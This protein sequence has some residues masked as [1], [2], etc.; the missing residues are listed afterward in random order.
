M[1]PK[2]A[3]VLM[4]VGVVAH[5]M[6]CGHFP[7]FSGNERF[8]LTFNMSRIGHILELPVTDWSV[9]FFI[10]SLEVIR[11]VRYI[12]AVESE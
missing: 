4:T 11:D 7:F 9:F 12:V 1:I 6:S 10:T 3:T 2:H 5:F 8:P